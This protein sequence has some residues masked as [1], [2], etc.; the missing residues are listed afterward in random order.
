MTQHTPGPWKVVDSGIGEWH[1][2]EETGSKVMT[3]KNKANARLIAAAP[4]LL[5]VAIYAGYALR[6]VL[7]KGH[8]DIDRASV[9]RLEAVIAAAT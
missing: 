6:S 8:P 1:I 2:Y 5:E 7:D 9:E 3:V 4:E